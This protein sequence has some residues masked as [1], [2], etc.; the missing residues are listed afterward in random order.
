VAIDHVAAVGV[1][2]HSIGDRDP[3]LTQEL[4]LP[5]QVEAAGLGEQVHQIGVVQ[6]DLAVGGGGDRGG[7]R[8]VALDRRHRIDIDAVLGVAGHRADHAVGGDV[9]DE[10]TAD[11]PQAVLVLLI[12]DVGHALGVALGLDQ[13]QILGAQAEGRGDRRQGRLEGDHRIGRARGQAA[14]VAAQ[15]RRQAVAAGDDAIDARQAAAVLR[16]GGGAGLGRGRLILDGGAPAEGEERG[17]AG[18]KS[19]DAGRGAHGPPRA[20]RGR[21]A[22]HHSRSSCAGEPHG[23]NSA[24]LRLRTAGVRWSRGPDLHRRLPHNAT[25]E[26]AIAPVRHRGWAA[27]PWLG[28]GRWP[29]R[30]TMRS[31]GRDAPPP[32][33]ST[34][35]G[36]GDE[37]S[38]GDRSS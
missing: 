37:N 18:A 3:V 24:S 25:P 38:G 29:T 4:E 1:D 28:P 21:S 34:T 33:A 36:R 16:R 31:C 26:A 19:Q 2:E 11:H 5:R 7:D 14:E 15:E 13:D 23:G 6:V 22:A 20:T 10:L 12:A 17:D 8:G 27:P 35:R 30:S 32:P 9:D